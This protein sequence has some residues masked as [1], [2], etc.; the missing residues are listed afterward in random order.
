MNKEITIKTRDFGEVGIPEDSVISFP[1]GIYAFEEEKQFVALSPLG[2]E[3]FPMWLQS[4]GNEGLCFIVYNPMEVVPDYNPVIQG[5]G[6][7]VIAADEGDEICY[8]S[9]ASIPE[10]FKKT[11]I[12]TKSPIVVNKTKRVAA[13]IIL[14]QDYQMRYPLFKNREGE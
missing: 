14:E 9:I 3:T 8:L 11:T 2:E 12:N 1:E 5:E 4:V 10:D 13:Q 7:D 6:S